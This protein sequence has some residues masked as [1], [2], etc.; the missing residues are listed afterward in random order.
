M[1]IETTHGSHLAGARA[2]ESASDDEMFAAIVARLPHATFEQVA[3]NGGRNGK[4]IILWR[5][6]VEPTDILR[7]S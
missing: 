3:H 4:K 7:G 6:S 2:P 5:Y 1:V